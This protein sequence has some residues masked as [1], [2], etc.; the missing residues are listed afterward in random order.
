MSISQP[1]FDHAYIR[2]PRLWLLLICLGYLALAANYAVQTPRWQAPDEPAH[3]N[4]IE[5]I[6]TTGTLPVLRMGDYDQEYL[7]YLLANRFPPGSDYRRLQY[8]SYQP[9]LYYLLATPIYQLSGGNLL[10]LRLFNSFLGLLFIFLVYYTL[11]TVFPHYTLISLGATAFTALLPMHMAV[12][13]A[14]NN[15]VLA[16]LLVA[17][18]IFVLLG[19]MRDQFAVNSSAQSA[20]ASAV[21]PSDPSPAGESQSQRQLLLLGLLLGLGLL[22]KIY[23]Y[24]LVPLCVLAIIATTWRADYS[25]RA[26]RQ[27]LLRSLYAVLPAL[28]LVLPWWIRSVRLYGAGDILGLQWHDR[29]VTGQPTTME[30]IAANGI[31]NYTERA[32]NFTFQS[33]W[34][35]FGWL[36][37]FM[38]GRI[39]TALLVCTGVLFLGL[40]WSLIRVIS[41]PPDSQLNSY[42]RWVLLFFALMVATVTASYIWYNLKFVQHQ[43]RYFFW[44]LLPISTFVALGWREVMRP[45]QGVITGILAAILGL[46]LAFTGYISGGMNK[47][48]VFAIGLIALLLLLQPLLFV[49]GEAQTPS[50]VPQRLRQ[51][52]AT[53]NGAVIFRGLRCS[54]WAVPFMLLFV[55]NALIPLLYIVPQLAQH[56]SRHH[57]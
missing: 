14:V 47:W 36:G 48:T 40:L 49:N 19:W 12:I 55:L 57:P 46:S 38:D 54:A 8:E 50:W 29:V 28:L 52:A 11:T 1:L 39:Y 33:F 53:P 42:Q 6:A 9:P 5:H 51:A 21:L 44:G 17:M 18:S 24:A 31:V 15:D 16:E 30:W 23:A 45:L 25:W 13:A 3:Y 20:E 10:A 56:V 41:G 43:G 7:N 34:G 27:G 22:T 4:Y 35:V 26:V 2:R 37:V 32:L